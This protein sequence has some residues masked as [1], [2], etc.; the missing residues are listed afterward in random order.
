[1]STKCNYKIDKYNTCNAWAMKSSEY[2]FTHNPDQTEKRLAANALGGKT[3]KK[4]TDPLPPI[5]VSSTKDIVKLLADTIQRVRDGS[6]DIR[7]GNSLA[8]ISAYLLKAI[9]AANLE[10][11][12]Q[13][14]ERI[15]LER[16]TRY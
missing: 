10:P 6:M 4:I 2:C 14:I 11:R 5:P 8:Y 13:E 16:E 7:V 15:I 9:D 12:L 1:M 3:P